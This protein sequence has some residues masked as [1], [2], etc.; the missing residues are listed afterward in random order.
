MKEFIAKHGC[1]IVI[2]L[3]VL[4]GLNK[5]TVSCNRGNEI[6]KLNTDIESCDSVIKVLVDSIG[7]LN[8]EVSILNEK[9][10]GYEGITKAKD[11]ALQRI[12]EAKKN[13]N[14]TVRK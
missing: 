11:E 7:T 6:K 9:I 13:I 5:C 1:K 8:T 3:L 4:F 10:N 14:V 12:T 2:V